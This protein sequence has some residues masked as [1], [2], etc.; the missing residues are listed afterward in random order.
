MLHCCYL[1]FDLRPDKLEYI[2][3]GKGYVGRHLVHLKGSHNKKL[4]RKLNK[5]KELNLTP[6]ISKID[7]ATNQQASMLERFWIK[8]IGRADLLLGS[9]CNY[10]N[11]GDGSYGYKPSLEAIEK[12]K[13]SHKGY[14][15][16]DE[17][18][19]LENCCSNKSLKSSLL[20]KDQRFTYSPGPC[21]EE[22]KQ[23]M[24]ESAM[25][26]S[27]KHYEKIQAS[28]LKTLADRK[29]SLPKIERSCEH[30]SCHKIHDGSYGAGRFCC[31]SCA[32]SFSTKKNILLHQ[33]ELI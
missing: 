8:T 7:C 5:I 31:T 1:Y 27:P 17:T 12:W 32:R 9:L 21:S 16:T 14:K 10:T 3:V 26:R 13:I 29:A 20:Q 4:D 24:S 23:K 28:R 18:K 6:I 25:K 22:T 2:Y 33:S 15:T 19:K 11:G 30:P